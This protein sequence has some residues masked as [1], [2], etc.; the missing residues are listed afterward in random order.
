MQREIEAAGISTITLSN[1]PELTAA[2]GVPRIAGIEHPFGRTVGM[3]GDTQGQLAVLRGAL[4]AL[5]EIEQPGGRADLP[6]E[7]P[8]SPKEASAPLE[9][10]PPIY[11]Y[12]RKH[13]TKVR[14][15]MNRDI[16]EEFRVSDG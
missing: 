11:H 16:P 14:N 2:V 5:V 8:E 1:I 10:L 7:W 3:P 15:F 6:F 9:E 12:L 4:R 13:I